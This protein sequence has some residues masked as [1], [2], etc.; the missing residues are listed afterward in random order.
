VRDALRSATRSD[1]SVDPSAVL[2]LT[3]GLRPS[4]FCGIPERSM[5]ETWSWQKRPSDGWVEGT[6]YTDGSLL[7]NSPE[8]EG[9]CARLGWAFVAVDCNGAV[10]AAASGRTPGSITTIFAAELWALWMALSVAVPGSG[11]R[12]D[13][14]SVLA[15]VSRGPR[16][17]SSPKQRY[18]WLWSSVAAALD[19]SAIDRVLC[20]ST[21]DAGAHC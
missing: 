20:V 8:F 2:W 4:P 11:I 12:T 9:H 18:A 21:L 5:M 16:W 15:G 1:G 14:K 6:I 3:R 13:C 7:D 10:V 17:A 19:D